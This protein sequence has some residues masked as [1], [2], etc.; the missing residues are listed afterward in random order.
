MKKRISLLL[1][2]V[3]SLAMMLTGC[4]SS[5]NASSNASSG[6]SSSNSDDEFRVGMECGYAPFNWTQSDDS[7]GGVKIQGNDEYAGG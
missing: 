1:V 5:N 7:N 6:S 2:M 4:S 3:M